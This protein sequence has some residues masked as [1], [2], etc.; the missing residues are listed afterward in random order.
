MTDVF[1]ISEA[2]LR[3]F[4]DLNNNVS[5]ELLRNA[6]REAQDIHIQRLTGTALYEKILSDIQSSSLTGAYQTLVNDYIQNALLYAAYYE[7]LEAIYIRPRNNGLLS[8]TGGENSEKVD[9]TWYDR[10]RESVK[11]KFDWYAE[12]LVNYLIENTTTYPE[13]NENNFLYQQY[14]DYGSQ[15][16]SPIVMRYGVRG[17]HWKEAVEAGLPISDSR[18]PQFPPPGWA[19]N[20]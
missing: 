8:P 2:K 19:K 14:P 9:G 12:K 1:I 15:F 17:Y 20:Y 5:T 4:T 11:N 10:K 18:F 7:A 3:Q 6:V 13:L 16:R